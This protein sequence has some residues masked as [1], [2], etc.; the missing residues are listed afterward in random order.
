MKW[1]ESSLERSGD[2][3]V[4]INT[5][6]KRISLESGT[7]Q[8]SFQVSMSYF[9]KRIKRLSKKAFSREWE[10]Q[11]NNGDWEVVFSRFY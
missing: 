5:K 2:V 7:A 9:N 4:N 11:F 6:S 10:L 8:V 1:M 3:S